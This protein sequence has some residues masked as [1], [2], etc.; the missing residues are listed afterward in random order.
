MTI[1]TEGLCVPVGEAPPELCVTLPGGFEVCAQTGEL[2][3]S[4]FGYAKLALGAAN[5]ALAPL[6]PIFSIIEAIFAIQNCLTAI[7]GILGPPPNPAKLLE[8]LGDL[9]QKM[10]RLSKLL[11]Q[12]SIPLL[13]VQLIDIIIATIDGAVVELASIARLKQQI[14]EAQQLSNTASGLLAAIE[15][16]TV[17]VNVQLSNIERSFAS[18]NPIIQVVNMLGALAGLKPLPPF[19]GGLGDDPSAAIARLQQAGD[20][21]RL[22]RS[23]IPF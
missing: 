21:L 3:P 16:A 17:S 4:L 7:P 22:V 1:L 13:V 11:P 6:G 10:E 23:A 15:C 2:P 8:A 5:S 19:E 14:Q 12:L 20:A 18:I 9:G